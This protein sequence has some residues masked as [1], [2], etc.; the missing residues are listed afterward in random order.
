MA[1]RSY[2]IPALATRTQVRRAKRQHALQCL[3]TGAF[4]RVQHRNEQVELQLMEL[5][6]G[7]SSV[8]QSIATHRNDCKA[9]EIP[10]HYAGTSNKAVYDAGLKCKRTFA[11]HRQLHQLANKVK[12]DVD[13]PVER[14]M[15]MPPM[16]DTAIRCDDFEQFMFSLYRNSEAPC[17]NFAQ[18]SSGEIGGLLCSFCGVWQPLSELGQRNRVEYIPCSA[19]ERGG[20]NVDSLLTSQDSQDLGGDGTETDFLDEWLH[21]EVPEPPLLDVHSNSSSVFQDKV[22]TTPAMP[23]VGFLTVAN[24]GALVAASYKHASNIQPFLAQ[25]VE[26]NGGC[27]VYTSPLT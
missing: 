4:Q 14:F 12:H 8:L 23:T 24:C 18:S 17:T 7:A 10:F 21:A 11:A 20:G 27:A 3:K 26:Q 9:M 6:A 1:A 22:D 19:I 5:T 25:V 2:I 15:P 16:P 13:V